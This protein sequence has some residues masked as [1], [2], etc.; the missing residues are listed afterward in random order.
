VTTQ[1]SDHVPFPPDALHTLH[2]YAV[3]SLRFV[4][5]VYPDLK[6]S[7]TPKMGKTEIRLDIEIGSG[8]VGRLN[9]EYGYGI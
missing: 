3:F 1:S 9:V 2:N 6:G 4:F 8:S 7:G 5:Q